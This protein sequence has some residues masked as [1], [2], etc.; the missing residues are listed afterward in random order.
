MLRFLPLAVLLA[1][2]SAA[3]AE[4]PAPVSDAAASHAAWH[5]C[6]R[7]AYGLRATLSGRDLAADAA[8]RACRGA[9]N[10]YL[11]ALSTSPLLDADDVTRV[12]PALVI[13]ARAWLTGRGAKPSIQARL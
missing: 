5:D 9:E 6:L 3:R 1:A 2:A 11:A 8:L 7:Q 4:P 10:A 13:K 12:R